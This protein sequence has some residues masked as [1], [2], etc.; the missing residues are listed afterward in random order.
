MAEHVPGSGVA[1]IS[2]RSREAAAVERFAAEH[3]AVSSVRPGDDGH[4]FE[5]GHE[6]LAAPGFALSELWITMGIDA[7][8]DPLADKYVVDVLRGGRMTWETEAFGTLRLAA[9]DVAV[10]PTVGRFLDLVEDADLDVTA[11]DAGR[12]AA[13][14]EQ[15]HG[16]PAERVRLTGLT[17]VSRDR[18]ARW[19]AT[20][21]HVRD[22]V[23]GNP[24]LL[25]DPTLLDAAFRR[26]ASAFLTTFPN[27]VL[28]ASARR[29]SSVA[30]APTR[31][32]REVTEYL[33][34]Y[35]GTSVGPHDLVRLAGVPAR[36]AVAGLR[37][38]GTDPATVLWRSRLAGAHHD[39]LAAGP[40][41]GPG[42]VGRIAA[43]WG[44]VRLGPFRVGY[45]REFGETPEETAA[46]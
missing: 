14:A 38:T 33:R 3:Y 23:L 1:R 12:V 6:T 11:L 9:G 46:R 19:D 37:R 17:P 34:T 21:V 44:F 25:D 8:V 5:V 7:L 15:V 35:A 40:D 10:M 32:A 41:S 4:P 22:R 42:L 16:V 18:A 43:R 39:L 13:F 24:M 29:R 26:L 28:A 2:F 27:T 36:D 31:T 30:A 20:V 45:A